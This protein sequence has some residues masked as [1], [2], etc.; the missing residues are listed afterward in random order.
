MEIIMKLG[1]LFAVLGLQNGKN[2]PGPKALLARA[3]KKCP[4][5]ARAATAVPAPLL[6]YGTANSII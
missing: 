6:Q 2:V 3:T 5:Q 4:G 1:K